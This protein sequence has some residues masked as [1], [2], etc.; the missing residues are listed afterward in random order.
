M[1]KTPAGEIYL[2]LKM[3]RQTPPPQS[4]CP[5]A[6]RMG[7]FKLTSQDSNLTKTYGNWHEKV[8]QCK[9]LVPFDTPNFM[10]ICLWVHAQ[11]AAEGNYTPL[12]VKLRE[13]IV[14]FRDTAHLNLFYVLD[15]GENPYKEHE[16]MRRQTSVLAAR[17]RINEAIEH[18]NEVACSDY[19]MCISNT[20]KYIA[21]VASLLQSLNVPYIIAP[22]E[23]DGQLAAL[24][25]DGVVVSF[26]HDMIALG[27]PTLYCVNRG[28]GWHTSDAEVIDV[29]IR[30]RLF[31]TGVSGVY[32]KYGHDG[33]QYFACLTRC[34]FCPAKCGIYG[35]G[36]VAACDLLLGLDP[37]LLPRLLTSSV[38]A[39][40]RSFSQMPKNFR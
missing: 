37:P 14:F 10:W 39:L 17:Q 36:V 38:Q 11:H 20:S 7:V 32:K 29:T 2:C 3:T 19:R 12:L 18:G 25:K 16:K 22:G 5:W 26:D 6:S 8:R 28:T 4:I 27:V 21:L 31:D 23:A 30:E 33:I 35:I 1:T 40:S 9:H 15:G 13:Y 34:N 24:A